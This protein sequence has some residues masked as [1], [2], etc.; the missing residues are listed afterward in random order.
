MCVHGLCA[1][2]NASARP[3]SLRSASHHV[4]FK[5]LDDAR[6]VKIVLAR[7]LERSL[8]A[9]RSTEIRRD[10]DSRDQTRHCYKTT[11]SDLACRQ[12]ELAHQRRRIPKQTKVVFNSIR[13]CGK[14]GAAQ[15]HSRGMQALKRAWR[16]ERAGYGKRVVFKDEFLKEGH[17]CV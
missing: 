9:R 3:W 10:T 2:A 12:R 5:P 15:A 13:G 1:N 8:R 11:I 17:S 4:R 7:Q 6:L 14:V 16:G